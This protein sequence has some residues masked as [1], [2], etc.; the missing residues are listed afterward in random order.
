MIIRTSTLFHAL[1]KQVA[2]P[3][4][5]MVFIF[6]VGIS[7]LDIVFKT[8]IVLRVPAIVIVYNDRARV[9]TAVAAP[10]T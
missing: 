9:T 7:K 5:G 1:V 3:V 8:F 10:T 2:Y 4:K 6:L